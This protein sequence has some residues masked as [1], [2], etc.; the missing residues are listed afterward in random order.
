MIDHRLSIKHRNIWHDW[1][2]RQGNDYLFRNLERDVLERHAFEVGK[3][4]HS[5]V[6]GCKFVLEL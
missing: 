3:R 4:W 1:Q 2:S 6:L 5:I